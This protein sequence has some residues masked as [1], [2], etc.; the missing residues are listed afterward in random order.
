M[1]TPTN[2][3]TGEL[4]QAKE[5]LTTAQKTLDSAMKTYE[6][7]KEPCMAP[8]MSYAERRQRRRDEI[9]ALK[10]ALNLLENGV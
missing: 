8:P 5:S 6:K 7:L 9:E 3:K 1:P 4:G 2:S 10:N